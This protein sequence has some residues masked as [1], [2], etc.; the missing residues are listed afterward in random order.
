MGGRSGDCWP[1]LCCGFLLFF[2]ES[3]QVLP[4]SDEAAVELSRVKEGK[5][6]RKKVG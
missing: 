3:C 4:M 6:S 2:G 1:F 5:T